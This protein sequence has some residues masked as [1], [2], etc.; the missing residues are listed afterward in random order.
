MIEVIG[1]EWPSTRALRAALAEV[2]EGGV[3]HW[4]Q[5]T[6]NKVEELTS[7]LV[8]GVPHPKFT[9]LREEAEEWRASGL[10]VWG[11]LLNHTQ[12]RDIAL[13]PGRRWNASAYWVQ[14]V[15]PIHQ[16]YRV[17]VWGGRGFRIGMKQRIE[18]FQLPTGRQALGEVVRSQR[19]GWGL[20]YS[21]ETLDTVSTSTERKEIRAIAARA[22]E[23]V[24]AA[25]GA[26]DVLSLVD[27]SAVVLEV[28]TAPALGENTLAA[29]V[30]V[31]RQQQD[32]KEGL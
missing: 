14:R 16:E 10:E 19:N 29:Y 31:I 13:L 2:E 25:G 12:G 5:R 15:Q 6:V 22:V 23:A 20:T 3:V 32:A 1:P 24:G 21:M 30:R 11:R 26:V 8:A 18:N 27:G 4:G 28:N 17:H 9:S 7:F